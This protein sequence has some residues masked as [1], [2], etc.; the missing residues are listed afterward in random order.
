MLGS[1]RIASQLI[2][3]ELILITVIVILISM[4]DLFSIFEIYDLSFMNN[5][6][7]MHATVSLIVIGLIQ[8][9][10]QFILHYLS[11]LP[12]YLGDYT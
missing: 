3:Y 2:S 8:L 12:I 6:V 11:Y 1:L 5:P 10:I 4:H 7:T 9:V